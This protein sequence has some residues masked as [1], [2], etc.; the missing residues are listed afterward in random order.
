MQAAE[1]SADAGAGD[2]GQ[3]EP[4]QARGGEAEDGQQ[5]MQEDIPAAPATPPRQARAARLGAGGAGQSGAAAAAPDAQPQGGDAQP[6]RQELGMQ[7]A[8]PFRS[9]GEAPSCKRPNWVKCCSWIFWQIQ[10]RL[11][12]G[13][14]RCT[15]P[16]D[17]WSLLCLGQY[18]SYSV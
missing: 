3:E 9:L 8:N 5:D 15:S 10:C 14:G 1:Q 12:K 16:W 17:Q 18:A 11:K 4:D 6:R 7:E 2:G 13:D